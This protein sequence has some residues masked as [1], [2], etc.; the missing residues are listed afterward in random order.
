MAYGLLGLTPGAFAALTP[1]DFY[2][3]VAA[4]QEE[5][6]FWRELAA[7]V[8]AHLANASSNL[9]QPATMDTLLG[10]EW[11]LRRIKQAERRKE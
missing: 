3:M 1:R 4:Q 5:R 8:V 6:L 9:K 7:W 10:P 11:T 2:E